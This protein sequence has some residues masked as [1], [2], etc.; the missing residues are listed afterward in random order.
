[1]GRSTM[2]SNEMWDQGWEGMSKQWSRSGRHVVLYSW[3]RPDKLLHKPK[4]PYPYWA[5]RSVGAIILG[6]WPS[7]GVLKMG[8]YGPKTGPEVIWTKEKS[9]W[10]ASPISA[11]Q[12]AYSKPQHRGATIWSK[13]ILGWRWVPMHL[14]PTASRQHPAWGSWCLYNKTKVELG[15]EQWPPVLLWVQMHGLLN[16]GQVLV[17]PNY[18]GL[19]YSSQFH[20]QELPVFKIIHLH[21]AEMVEKAFTWVLFGQDL[22]AGREQHSV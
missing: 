21:W 19:A 11:L 1:M 20:C 16:I 2:K 7:P 4:H 17:C 15:K 6:S 12:M 9:P 22:H 14:G 10:Q 18:D 8:M 3:C 5:T 13:G